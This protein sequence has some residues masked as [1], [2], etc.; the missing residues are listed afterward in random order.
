MSSSL[1]TLPTKELWN[2]LKTR[3]FKLNISFK[4]ELDEF[5]KQSVK[6]NKDVKEVMGENIYKQIELFK[7][8]EIYK[9]SYTYYAT[10]FFSL[11]V[12]NLKNFYRYLIIQWHRF[13]R[14]QQKS[15]NSDENSNP[16]T[17]PNNTLF[18]PKLLLSYDDI[19]K[20]TNLKL[21]QHT[22]L[23]SFTKMVDEKQTYLLF[24]I[25]QIGIY[26]LL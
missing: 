21:L 13:H 15:V 24:I 26:L 6:S 11:D 12:S 23:D 3:G 14:Y 19:S 10:I 7:K 17:P 4:K 8:L 16:P 1:T 9:L 20:I 2:R 25:N 5:E 18:N 22:I